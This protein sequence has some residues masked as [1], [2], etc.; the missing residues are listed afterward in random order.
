M[1]IRF[2]PATEFLFGESTD[3]LGTRE[4][5]VKGEKFADCFSYATEVVGNRVRL[6]KLAANV[7]DKSYE[8]S[9]KFIHEYIQHYVYR[10][11]EQRSTSLEKAHE[12]PSKYV[13]LEQLAKTGN[14]PKEIQDELTNILLAGR[15][16]T[17]SLLAHCDTYWLNGRTCSISLELK[18][19]A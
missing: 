5:R 6:G 15:D 14:T 19:C 7:P 18:F 17:A 11:L 12:C 8:D 1:L 3:V 4:S 16:T 9:K 2:V 10:T 13:F